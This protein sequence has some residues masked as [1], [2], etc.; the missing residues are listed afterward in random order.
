M[1]TYRITKYNPKFRDKNDLYTKN[2]WASISDIN[3]IFD[4]GVLTQSEYL[5]VEKN[6]IEAIRLILEELESTYLKLVGIE[7]HS[8]IIE[9]TDNLMYTKDDELIY[10]MSKE[11]ALLSINDGLRFSKLIFRE[12][13]WGYLVNREII[14]RIGFDY[15]LN[16]TLS[17]NLKCFDFIENDL[18]LYIG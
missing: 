13:I 18:G 15:Y 11:G 1:K 3:N 17:G 9:K 6:Y 10:Q 5:R 12:N 7:K 4:D 8:E 14:I 16:V 2:E